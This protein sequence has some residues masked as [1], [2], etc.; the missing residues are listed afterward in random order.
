MVRWEQSKKRRDEGGWVE[1]AS[2]GLS[3]A[4][5]CV[6]RGVAGKGGSDGVMGVWTKARRQ[7][8]RLEDKARTQV[9][10]P[11]NAHL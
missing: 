1:S 5:C 4:Y 9:T 10:S 6:D 8:W 3:K 7:M 11:G 2:R